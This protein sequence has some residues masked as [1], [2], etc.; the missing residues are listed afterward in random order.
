MEVQ[1]EGLPEII[2]KLKGKPYHYEGHIAPHDIRVR[3]LGTGTSR[4]EV[5]SKLGVN[6]MVCRQVPLMD[7]IEATRNLLKRAY[8]DLRA[9][10]QGYDALQLYRSEYDDSK[11]IY[12]NRPIHD[13][14]SHAADALRMFAVEMSQAGSQ[15]WGQGINYDMLNRMAV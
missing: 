6:F 11:Q 5:A 1:G 12:S 4:F 13:W 14:T 9:C 8:I 10:Q 15:N 2:G 7:G 3:E